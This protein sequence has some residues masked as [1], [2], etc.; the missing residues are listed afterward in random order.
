MKGSCCEACPTDKWLV[1]CREVC[2]SETV[3]DNTFVALGKDV[4]EMRNSCCEACSTDTFSTSVVG[5]LVSTLL[6]IAITWGIQ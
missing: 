5:G 3:S 2:P 1:S 4:F 6:L